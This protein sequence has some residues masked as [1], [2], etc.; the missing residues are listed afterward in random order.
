MVQK[1]P[2]RIMIYSCEGHSTSYYYSDEGH[3]TSYYYSDEGHRTS[4]YYSN[5]SLSLKIISGTKIW[6]PITSPDKALASP[7]R[8]LAS[9]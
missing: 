7:Y 6:S 8:A 3:S 5:Y 2:V 9:Q 4:Y 1:I